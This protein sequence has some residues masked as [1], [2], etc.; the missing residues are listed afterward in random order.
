MVPPI[1]EIWTGGI[2]LRRGPIEYTTPQ[3]GITKLQTTCKTHQWSRDPPYN[4]VEWY[5]NEINNTPSFA[6]HPKDFLALEGGPT[7]PNF[8]TSYPLLM[9]SNM[10]TTSTPIS[11]KF[12]IHKGA[13]GGFQASVLYL[14]VNHATGGLRV[15]CT[16]ASPVLTYTVAAVPNTGSTCCTVFKFDLPTVNIV[17]IEIYGFGTTFNVF[18]VRMGPRPLL[19]SPINY[20]TVQSTFLKDPAFFQKY[21][22]TNVADP[23]VATYA[24][25]NPDIF[26]NCYSGRIIYGPHMNTA[27]YKRG[28]YWYLIERD[29]QPG[30]SGTSWGG[31]GYSSVADAK[32]PGKWESCYD[33]YQYWKYGTT[34][35]FTD[36]NGNG[37]FRRLQSLGTAKYP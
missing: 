4:N 18:G 25:K 31:L 30:A 32:G 36:Q 14:Y 29:N 17:D 35:D 8:M 34:V 21:G 16:W 37:W 28:Q 12:Q 2:N 9:Q 10:S 23:P 5:E 19:P 22:F 15:R 26:P 6:V 13:F 27:V 3:E 33:L 7:D 1:Y 20:I 11:N 24:F